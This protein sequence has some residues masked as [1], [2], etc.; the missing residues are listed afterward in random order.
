[1]SIQKKSLMGTHKTAKKAKAVSSELNAKASNSARRITK[2]QYG[3]KAVDMFM[4]IT[5][6]TD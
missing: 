3:T 2:R 4:K 1:M 5:S 6:G